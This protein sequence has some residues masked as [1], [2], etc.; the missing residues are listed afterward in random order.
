MTTAE[1]TEQLFDAIIRHD[2]ERT[3][4]L[5][6]R[7]ADPNAPNQNGWRPLHTALGQMDVGG[8]IDFV[9]LLLAHGA[10]PNAWDLNHHETPILSASDLL[11]VENFEGALVLLDAGADPNVRRSDGESPLRLAARWKSRLLAEMLLKHGAQRTI[12]EFGGDWAW[13]ALGHAAHNFDVD[14]IQMLLDAGA[15]PKVEDETGSTARDR[16]PPR[17]M[18]DPNVW[19][20]V[21]EILS[22]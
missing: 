2:L 11:D 12:D 10:D 3:R 22:R 16:L 8:S 6:S 21:F 17:E 18:C 15:D 4:T 9:K 19:D 13:T 5:L 20:R 7:G 1:L 14:M